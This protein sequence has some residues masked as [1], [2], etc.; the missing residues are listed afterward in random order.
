M[1]F[2]KK[3]FCIVL[4]LFGLISILSSSSIIK[5]YEQR[6]FAEQSSGCIGKEDIQSF[7]SKDNFVIVSSDEG[8]TLLC[9]ITKDGSEINLSLPGDYSEACVADESLFI[10]FNKPNSF[11]V[12]C[13]NLNSYTHYAKIISNATISQNKFSAIDKDSIAFVD[14]SRPDTLTICNLENCRRTDIP[15]NENITSI[16]SNPSHSKF[17]V[18]T[19]NG[20]FS[21]VT[22]DFNS[23]IPA[24]TINADDFIFI[25]DETIVANDGYIYKLSENM[26]IKDFFKGFETSSNISCSFKN[27][28]ITNMSNNLLYLIDKNTAKPLEQLYSEN[29]ILSVAGSDS[30]L[31]VVSKGDNGISYEIKTSLS[32]LEKEKYSNLVDAL[33]PDS[34]NNLYQS[35]APKCENID[36]IY[37]SYPDVINYSSPGTLS[38]TVL[39]DSINAIN[40]HRQS[41][42]LS[43]M[44][45]DHD[46]CTKLQYSAVLALSCD[47]YENPTKPQ[48]MS[49]EFFDLAKEN[50][51]S[52]VIFK[53][54][55][56]TPTVLPDTIHEMF[57]SNYYFRNLVISN[58]N[59]E[60]GFALASD[61]DGN[62]AVVVS[63]ADKT[64]L[65]DN[66]NFISYPSH[67]FCPNKWLSDN[68]TIS[69]IL[70][71]DVLLCGERGKP[72]ATITNTSTGESTFVSGEDLELFSENKCIVF[73]CPLDP[74]STDTY[75]VTVDN[76]YTPKG[77]A[78]ELEYTFTLF[79]LQE[80]DP[81]E[82]KLSSD[83]YFINP[84]SHYIS[85]IPQ[86]TNLSEFKSNVS[87]DTQKYTLE[88]INYSGKSISS[89]IVGTNM[90]VLL[91]ENNKVNQE[92]TIVIYGDVTGEGNINN[93]DTKLLSNYLLGKVNIGRTQLIAADVKHDG[94][95]DTSDLLLLEKYISEALAI[96]QK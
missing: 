66:D 90:K 56:I 30:S 5:I 20:L 80:Y 59:A 27:N 42:S 29:E 93:N 92:Y 54:N 17:Y 55:G 62:F 69:V 10:T 11:E 37:L 87:Y 52:S 74:S 34:I 60:I 72:E 50:L 41:L 8:S 25:D 77:I 71:S 86:G 51:S 94:K 67:G 6:A 24:G 65:F 91:K 7:Y 1:S 43:E 22:S 61:D 4:T 53:G 45:I 70:N 35:T 75:S 39:N 57:N 83:V 47:D 36:S 63:V 13:Y 28:I 96:P 9:M 40:F 49:D 48:N 2:G 58:S 26:F 14:T 88:F 79:D 44:G 23:L 73:N 89:G 21:F 31:L 32:E 19:E 76:I 38:D 16:S 3:V 82:A 46:L 84:V 68:S 81:T 18:N 33:T 95:V 64:L 78:A 85:G 15:I 12:I